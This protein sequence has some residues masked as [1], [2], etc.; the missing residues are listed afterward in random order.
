[1]RALRMPVWVLALLFVVNSAVSQ[2]KTTYAY[3]ANVSDNTVSV[4]N[5]STN[6]VVKTISVG[7]RPFAV[8]VDQAGKNAYV[9]NFGSGTVSV[10]STS[11]NAVTAT[12]PVQNQ[13][14]GVAIA[15]NGKTAYVANGGSSSV[16][17]INTGTKKVTA[18]ITVQNT[19][20]GMALPSSGAFLY[21]VNDGSSSV[22]VISTLTNSVVAT[23][24]VGGF[25]ATVAISP[26]QTTAYVTNQTS[27]SVSVIRTADNTVVNTINIPTGGPYGAAVSP[28]GHWLYVVSSGAV[29]VLDMS[30][31]T[32]SA[33]IPTGAG[34][35]GLVAFSQ[36]SASAYV[37]ETGTNS[38][39]V[40]STANKTVSKTITVGTSPTGV[41]LKGLMHVS[42]DAGG[43]VGDKGP[44][45]KAALGAPYSSVLDSAGNLYIA[46][47]MSNR[48]RKVD[49]SNT[50]TTYAGTGIWGYN[51]DNIPAASATVGNPQGL[52]IDP[53]GNVIIADGGNGRVR[54]VD[55]STGKINT[56][57]GNG[58]FADTGDGG[59]A[60]NASIGQA[61]NLAYDS[62][63]NL[64]IA[65]V[66]NLGGC[67]V[68][69]VD[70]NGI[71]HTAA[72]NG[73]CGYNGDGNPTLSELNNPRGVAVDSSG[74]LYIGDTDNCLVRKVSGGT[75]STFAGIYGN[76]GFGP[77]GVVATSS[78]VGRPTTLHVSNNILYISN[79]GRNRVRAVDLSTN[80]ISTYAGSSIGYDGDGNPLTSSRF[81]SPRLNVFD[82]SG[83]P[84]IDDSFNG[85]VRKATAGI[86]NTIAGGFVGEGVSAT[87]TSFGLMEALAIDKAGNLYIA[88]ETG[89][90]I[91]KVSGG[92][93][94]TVAGTGI[95]GY[96][97]DNG[98]ATSA[99][100]NEPQGVAVDSVGNVFIADTFN[101]VIR[102]VDTSGFIHPFSTNANY[103]F[104]AQMATDSSNN[105]Y[106]ADA[107]ACVI[108]KITPPPGA[109][110][111]IAAGTLNTCSYGGDGGAATLA[112]LN[113][114][115]AVAFDSGG[116]MFIADYGNS[117]VR[118]VDVK[119]NI[120]TVAGNG[121]CGWTGDGGSATA[122]ELCPN[123]VAV[124]K[125][126]NIYV[127]DFNFLKIR[128]IS[129]GIITTF[130]GAG[131]GFDGDG[132]WPLYTTFDDPVAVAVDSKGAVYVLDDWD[133]RVRKIQ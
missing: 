77:D 128:K 84:I 104:L 47:A 19:P 62:T 112:Q 92:K 100:I 33:T 130:A 74:N 82:P 65:V 49:T 55:H 43:F 8:A 87:A 133:H 37:T 18:T 88:D 40:I 126:H 13:P 118:E 110:V 17:V 102:Y 114:P 79:G 61:F 35:Y 71:I 89:N 56:I 93:V 97:G 25:P 5:T 27:N 6:A 116:N 41:A 108:W 48:I 2:A 121:T 46:D 91:R 125:S 107:G 63:G 75:L 101:N 69:F 119:G 83:N 67:V 85:R 105:V 68:R 52:T 28:D 81:F 129:G 45:T 124:D 21:V 59:P 76:C 98:P 54:K 111:S 73:T 72:G 109:V 115:N 32:I 94:T 9:T 64:Y 123:S 23:V 80:L 34:T 106:V 1:M 57:A 58:L 103:S 132:L 10:I 96:T 24:P 29:T 127:A 14:E 86:V 15:P 39:Y 4:I 12:I 30:T 70:T 53:S 38:V 122:A 120:N 60:T 90:R 99:E 20:A 131:F 11:T 31:L 3:V 16:S 42:T 44:A 51:G 26:D 117:R 36:D 66:G 22:S 78:A 95:N 50:I 113:A 7:T